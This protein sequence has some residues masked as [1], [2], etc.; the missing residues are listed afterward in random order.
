MGL[1]APASS[2]QQRPGSSDAGDQASGTE[3]RRLRAAASRPAAPT[4]ENQSPGLRHVRG[5]DVPNLDA[6]GD[7]ADQSG[8]QW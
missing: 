8:L 7:R 5:G 4:E 3:R 2:R 6:A 1:T